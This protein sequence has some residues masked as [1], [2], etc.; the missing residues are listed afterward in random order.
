MSERSKVVV[1]GVNAFARMIAAGFEAYGGRRVVAHTV[2]ERF[3]T[4][5]R[6]G[7][8][9]A[10]AFETLSEHFDPAEHEIFVAIEHARQNV[11]RGEIL[12]EAKRLG[13][14][15]ASLISPGAQ[16]AEDVVL[17]EH[18]LVLE[19]AVI[20]FGARMGRNNFLFAHSFFGQDTR[21]GDHNYFGSGFFADRNVTI[22]SFSTFG[23]KVRVAES[24]R[25]HDWTFV[26]PLHDVNET[27]S[28]PTFIHAALR[29]P[30]RVV[31][32]RTSRP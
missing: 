24:V 9:P 29:A 20:Q 25:V 11:A 5:P 18:C 22:G 3:L 30:G 4:E 23:S 1:F 17:G 13:Y 31:D 2:H 15:P 19:N 27:L 7:S 32:R 10:V 8:K 28:E 16:I 26:K 14:R 6:I 12:D 21:V